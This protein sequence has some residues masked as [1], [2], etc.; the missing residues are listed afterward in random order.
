MCAYN[1]KQA[2]NMIDPLSFQITPPNYYPPNYYDQLPQLSPSPSHPPS[3]LISPQPIHTSP[4]ELYLKSFGIAITQH[5]ADTM[6]LLS[7]CLE[8]ELILNQN[9]KILFLKRSFLKFVDKDKVAYEIS[10]KELNRILSSS[11]FTA[12]EQKTIRKMRYQGRNN[13]AAKRM[14]D[15]KKE[16]D[17]EDK[18]DIVNMQREK[19]KLENEKEQ[20]IKEIEQYKQLFNNPQNQ[21]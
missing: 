18:L 10:G 13:M 3:V 15:K 21:N 7:K 5:E 4:N 8:S 6:Y 9:W 12:S 11:F 17:E 14:R 16:S 20:M 2:G 1:M 19:L